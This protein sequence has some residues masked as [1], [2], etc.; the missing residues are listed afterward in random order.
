MVGITQ[1]KKSKFTLRQEFLGM[2][3]YS[4]LQIEGVTALI[5]PMHVRDGPSLTLL[6]MLMG[7]VSDSQC[8][9]NLGAMQRHS[10]TLTVHECP[11]QGPTLNVWQQL[12]IVLYDED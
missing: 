3:S 9:A 10:G 11:I 5:L 1:G 2:G 8:L 6:H 7:N 4:S 12:A